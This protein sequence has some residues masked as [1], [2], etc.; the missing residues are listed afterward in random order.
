MNPKLSLKER[1]FVR[2]Y[3]ETGNKTEAANIAGY[4]AKDRVSLASIGYQTFK[5]LQIKIVDIM[6]ETGLTDKFLLQK[7][8]EGLDATTV[9]VASDKGLI[10][11]ERQYPDYTARAKYLEMALR[12]KELLGPERGEE[13]KAVV[14]GIT[15]QVINYAN[16]KVQPK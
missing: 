15:C 12:L 4:K 8:I 1:K 14:G 6:E 2:A 7:L 9:K 3:L 13:G 16:M 5:K 10:K 11:N